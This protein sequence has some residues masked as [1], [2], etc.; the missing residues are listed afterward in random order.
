MK[1]RPIIWPAKLLLG[2]VTTTTVPIMGTKHASMV[3]R[4]RRF[5]HLAEIREKTNAAMVDTTPFGIVKREASTP[6]Y[7]RLE[8][9][10]PPNVSRPPLGML[11]AM[12]KKKISQV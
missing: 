4:H 8:M 2:K 11:I 3:T 5:S 9:M 10:M 1:Y 12:L 7:P 6:E